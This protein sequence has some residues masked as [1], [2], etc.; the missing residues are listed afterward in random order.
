MQMHNEKKSMLTQGIWP[1]F[2]NNYKWSIIFKNCESLHCSWIYINLYINYTLILKERLKRRRDCGTGTW[3]L[4]EET[5]KVGMSL[6]I[7]QITPSFASWGN[8]FRVGEWLVQGHTAIGRLKTSI[9]ICVTPSPNK[10]KRELGGRQAHVKEEWWSTL[11]KTL[12]PNVLSS[13]KRQLRKW[14][15]WRWKSVDRQKIDY[16]F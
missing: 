13:S 11:F 2:S 14:K 7:F 9:Q 3:C 5:K 12:W 10:G 1:K 8:R 16:F 6:E 15:R 4:R